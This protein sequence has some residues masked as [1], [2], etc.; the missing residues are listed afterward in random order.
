MQKR[1]INY[2]AGLHDPANSEIHTNCVF[3]ECGDDQFE[4]P[5]ESSGQQDSVLDTQTQDFTGILDVDYELSGISLKN[6]CETVE[7]QSSIT[8]NDNNDNNNDSSAIILCEYE[9]IP[10][11]VMKINQFSSFIIQIRSIINK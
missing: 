7:T 9:H 11:V 3:V 6:V 10:D 2:V 8:N 1:T 4:E 5:E